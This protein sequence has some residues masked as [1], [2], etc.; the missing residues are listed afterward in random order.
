MVNLSKQGGKNMSDSQ[1]RLTILCE[2]ALKKELKKSIYNAEFEKINDGYL[3]IL[4]LG[5]KALNQ[6]TK[7]SGV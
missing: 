4:K 3:E 7:E 1:S 5:I 2:S 6:K